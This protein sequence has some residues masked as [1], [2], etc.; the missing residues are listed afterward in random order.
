MAQAAGRAAAVAYR[1]H[2]RWSVHWHMIAFAVERSGHIGRLAG[3]ASS[4]D[5][6][7]RGNEGRWHGC[8]RHWDWECE[9]R[10]AI[11]AALA[12]DDVG[13]GGE[14]TSFLGPS[15]QTW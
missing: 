2:G 10:Q 11:V 1:L 15:I 12:V 14:D 3:W 9:Y 4:G 7:P 13:E 5:H 6:A 8:L